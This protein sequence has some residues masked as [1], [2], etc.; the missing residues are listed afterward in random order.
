[1]SGPR[2]QVS[3]EEKGDSVDAV[4]RLSGLH[5]LF[6]VLSLV[7]IGAAGLLAA[8]LDPY[9][10]GE[11]HSQGI[12][13]AAAYALWL[14]AIVA[15]HEAGHYV[16]A[17]RCNIPVSKPYFLPG[18]GPIPGLGVIP[19]FGTFGAFIK[20]QMRRLKARD[21]MAVAGWGPLAGFV[22]TLAAVGL[23]VALS[24]PTA[25]SAEAEMLILGDSLLLKGAT[26]LFHPDLGAHQELMLHPIGLAGWVGCL[27]TSLNLLP[28]GQLDGG[29]LVYGVLGERS[30]FVSYGAFAGLLG[31]GFFVF[32]G[33]LMLALLV[34]FM[35]LAHP[36]MLKGKPARGRQSWMIWACLVVFILT[37][38]PAPVVVDNIPTL[39]GW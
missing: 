35:G 31:L 5:I 32:P 28:L 9:A 27:L 19:F 26:L 21:L 38:S 24:E 17:R 20:M 39:L 18:L 2:P 8:G 7:T 6:F 13:Q 22:V 36:P 10:P 12:Y 4:G 33:W 11:W 3:G 14:L 25:V 30:R 34:G 16:T 1:M 15:S 29:H 23:G 37:F